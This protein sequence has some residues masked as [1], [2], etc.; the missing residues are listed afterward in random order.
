MSKIVKYHNIQ[1]DGIDYDDFP[2]FCDAF[3][4]AADVELEDGTIR[5]ATE[6]ELEALNDDG[7]FVYQEVINKLF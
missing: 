2:D 3:V 4:C 6:D 7:H 5:E 1:L